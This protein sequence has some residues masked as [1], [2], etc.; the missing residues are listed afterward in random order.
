MQFVT[1]DE[2]G[3]LKLVDLR[4]KVVASPCG[5]QSRKNAAV[6]MCWVSPHSSSAAAVVTADG[7]LNV[8][9]LASQS[10]LHSV[11]N[12]GKDV[13]F[14]AVRDRQYVTVSSAGAVCIFPVEAR[15][16]SVASIKVSLGMA[17][18]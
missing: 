17:T 16:A 5:F 15:D 12:V 11:T 10:M 13:V 18:K 7:E 6:A 8:W 3:L 1:G 4:R 9:D 2:T 14:L